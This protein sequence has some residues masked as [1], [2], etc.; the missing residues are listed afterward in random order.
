MAQPFGEKVG[1]VL[2]EDSLS[3]IGRAVGSFKDG[4]VVLELKTNCSRT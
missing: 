2:T 1:A 4:K 3:V